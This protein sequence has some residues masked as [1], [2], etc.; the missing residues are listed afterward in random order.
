MYQRRP[1]ISRAAPSGTQRKHRPDYWLLMLAMA[2]LCVGLV[3]I[4]SISPGLSAVE[5]R[6]SNYYIGKQVIAVLLGLGTFAFAANMPLKWWKTATLPL[7]GIATVTTMIVS[8]Q[9]LTGEPTRWINLG[10]FS[11]QPAEVVKLAVIL[12]LSLFLVERRRSGVLGDTK[13]TLQP[14]LIAM[15]VMG[16]L[17][18]II[19]KDLGS[20][21]VIAA[22]MLVMLFVSGF[23]V[24]K[25]AAVGLVLLLVAPFAILHESYRVDRVTTFL[26]PEKGCA[27][28]AGYQACQ[29]LISVGS[30]GV[31]GLGLGNSV[32]A[33]GYQPEAA[34]DSI[35]AILAEKFGF[36]GVTAL[37]LLFATFLTRIKR[38]MEKA[39]DMY[40]QLLVTGVFT[41]L[42]IQSIINIGGMMGLLPLKGITLPFISYGGTSVVF[43]MA[44]LGLVFQISRYSVY[45]NISNQQE[46]SRSD[47]R[48]DRGRLG[49]AYN[50]GSGS[51][52][53]A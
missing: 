25:L 19:E 53:R 27:T 36:I 1:L 39:P 45:G 37:L 6:S 31:I 34:N 21:A 2:L 9:S 46:A 43:V 11:F 28:A 30:G 40:M 13:K 49:R 12:S 41:W 4:Y 10:A 5:G 26:H 48:H 17:T 50:A 38:V 32:Q 3:V 35:F 20:M 29:A 16:L 8:I 44:A 7:V 24:K 51:S 15:G 14:F 47:Y 22:V 23:P 52:S 33:Y 42:S 18:V